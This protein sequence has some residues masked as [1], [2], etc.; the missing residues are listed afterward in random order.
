MSKLDTSPPMLPPS[1]APVAPRRWHQR[2]WVRVVG[3][4]AAGIALILGLLSVIPVGALGR[5]IPG[6]AIIDKSPVALKPGQ[7]RGVSDRVA[8]DQSRIFEPAGQIL[9]TTVS[10]DDQV[11][12]LE[13]L[14]AESDSH[15]RLLPHDVVF[16]DRSPSEN[17]QRNLQ[18]MQV[19]KETA[20]LVAFQY[21]GVDVI[22]E[23]GIGFEEVLSDGP[24]A[25]ILKVGDIIVQIDD[26]EIT[27]FTTLRDALDVRGPGDE[28]VM[29]LEDNDTL[30]RREETLVLGPHPDDPERAFIGIGNVAT[31]AQ[32]SDLPFDVSIDSGE[33]GG[34]SA[35]LAFTLS[36]IDLLT[37]GELTGGQKVAVTGTILLDETV[38]DV[39]GAEQKA[40]G[41][42]R[43]GADL[44]IVPLGEV[45]EAEKGAGDM[46][47]VGVETL[48]D[49]LNALSEL[50]GETSDLVLP[51]V[52][53]DSTN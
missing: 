44:F 14:D 52:A 39:G 5:V 49:A 30:E 38:G 37:P 26:A 7:A 28:I 11:S 23:T 40:V 53:V 22:D 6:T 21:F 17:R 35:G 29:I 18:M 32:Q 25:G 8:I 27:S 46:P 19:S 12:I 34:P 2:R 10:I 9:F 1:A 48:E 42:R 33:I 43:A 31:R 3:V 45:A 16:G 36:I 13:W 51:G 15:Q 20:V 41:A 24:A 50:G 4:T 47:V